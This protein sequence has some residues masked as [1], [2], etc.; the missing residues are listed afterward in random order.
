MKRRYELRFGL[1]GPTV[2]YDA[3]GAGGRSGS[4]SARDSDGTG[5]REA[6]GEV[7]EL[8][9]GQELREV[10]EAQE[11]DE[12]HEA[13]ELHG[14]REAQE[15]QPVD[16]LGMRSIGSPKVRT[17]LAALLLEAGRVVP[18]ESLEEVLWGG[19]P[20][21]S[22]R[23]SLHN[24][25]TRLRRLLD[26]PER[27]RAVPPGYL[28]RVE[29][30][31]L[32]V[33]AFESHLAAARAAHA[34]RNWDR[35][36]RECVAGLA[37]WRGTPLSGLPAELGGYAF[38]Q[39]FQEA[40]LL[41]LEWR[42]DADLALGGTR[43]DRVLPEL[44]ALAVDHPLRESYQRQLMLA[45]HRTGRQAEA[46]AVHRDLRT[47]L[48]DELGVEPGRSVR[49]AHAEVLRGA[50]EADAVKAPADGDG[51]A[52]AGGDVRSDRAGRAGGGRRAGDVEW[53]GG[54]G[55]GE[56]AGRGEGARRA[57]GV[58]EGVG[59]DFGTRVVGSVRGEGDEAA[60]SDAAPPADGPASADD[61]DAGA[62][63]A[64]AAL[65]TPSSTPRR[66]DAP[67][68][69]G[70]PTACDH[71][72][73]PHHLRQP[74]Q[75]RQPDHLGQPG[76]T[77]HPASPGATPV[78]GTAATDTPTP[79]TGTAATGTPT[80]A[81]GTP[82]PTAPLPPAQLPPPPA[83]FTGRTDEVRRLHRTLTEPGGGEGAPRVAVVS[84]MAG[85]GKSALALRVAH[86]LRER[87]PD[88]QLYLDLQGATP[89]T[90]PLPVDQALA[91]LLRDLGTEPHRIPERHEARSALLRTLLAPTRTLILLDDAAHA[92]QVRP[93]LP[94]GPGC[95]VLVTSRSPLTVLDGAH[96]FPLA[97]LS[98]Q[99]SAA[100]LRAVSGRTGLDAS[101][102]LVDLTGRLP[103]ALRVVAARLAA[104]RAL[105]PDVLA[106]QLATT[107]G[108]LSRLEYDD[109]SVRRS[110]AVTRDALAASDREADRDAALVL[111]RIG[112][113]DQPAY[114]TSL[115]ARLTGID[116]HRAEAALD[117][118]VDVALLEETTY[119]RY[120]LHDLVR[121]FA[122][123]LATADPE[124]GEERPLT[125]RPRS[126]P[127]PL[128]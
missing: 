50:G 49:D 48:I 71:R 110:L 113:L 29:W 10:R 128:S 96:R 4:G 89:G 101:H 8:H 68:F 11:A 61:P 82:D 80:P 108:R 44:A 37:L 100:L 104:R 85:V 25:V 23:A 16:G 33:H 97:P 17:L 7:R 114:G 99:E 115:L 117:R 47:R 67:S 65:A 66:T 20:P 109:L 35:V 76:R 27:L 18:V 6:G 32:D 55:R 24:H 84:G 78:T 21:A 75:S 40:R 51:T 54:A 28:L 34:A 105:T 63:P 123:E 13:Q 119:G 91:S 87:F 3:E 118:L 43:L 121:E 45:L 36:V 86:T 62:S 125:W 9:G 53:A 58:R 90:I 94:A 60:S 22:A 70:R 116:E 15:L 5:A 30:G 102:P 79:A 42:Y 122:R 57:D 98:P 92:A 19:A 112:A 120:T 2:L 127:P 64:P 12:V 106:G 52:L 69:P 56:D 81:T 126:T 38:V 1:L 111:S 74:G 39:R 124:S 41:L 83:A 31:E 73:H 93:L 103:L 72:E 26:D 14:V 77:G 88:G 107:D 46:L 59:A 95:A